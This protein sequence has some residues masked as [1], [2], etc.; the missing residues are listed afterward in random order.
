MCTAGSARRR[1]EHDLAPA[2]AQDARARRPW[3]GVSHE[4]VPGLPEHADLDATALHAAIG[5]VRRAQPQRVEIERLPRLV[6]QD[7]AESAPDVAVHGRGNPRR[8]L[9]LDLGTVFAELEAG[10]AVESDRHRPGIQPADRGVCDR[11][12]VAEPP[13]VLAEADAARLDGGEPRPRHQAARSSAVSR[14][15]VTGPSFTRFTAMRAWKRPV[16]TRTWLA[17]AAATKR[18]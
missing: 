6:V 15:M 5:D 3:L 7:H 17:R 12:P 18:S 1:S 11:L 8:V 2:G 13:A 14:M 9:D 16:S 10:A 4:L